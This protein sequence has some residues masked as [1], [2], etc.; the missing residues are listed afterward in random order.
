MQFP[1]KVD[2]AVLRR[3]ALRRDA[4]GRARDTPGTGRARAGAPG[5]RPGAPGTRPGPRPGREILSLGEIGIPAAIGPGGRAGQAAKSLRVPG[6]ALRAGPYGPTRRAATVVQAVSPSPPTMLWGGPRAAGSKDRDRAGRAAYTIV[7][8]KRDKAED[9][10]R[11]SSVC[12]R[13]RE[14]APG[15]KGA[16]L[17]RLR[18]SRGMGA[19]HWD[20]AKFARLAP[21]Q[22]AR[23]RTRPALLRDR[24][25]WTQPKARCSPSGPE[26]TPRGSISAPG[27]LLFFFLRR[28]TVHILGATPTVQKKHLPCC[29]AWWA[30]RWCW[31]RANTEFT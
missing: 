4:P 16:T 23:V 14:S 21:I 1:V 15:K 9:F 30:A 27:L 28:H 12:G 20:F 24:P 5:T 6:H 2:C 26:G 17:A 29:C 3:A 25:L 13:Q 18:I 19:R 8:A 31:H 11:V 10:V 7:C 22:P